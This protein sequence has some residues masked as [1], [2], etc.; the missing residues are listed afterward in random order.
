M[1][2]VAAGSSRT[3]RLGLLS[4][5]VFLSAPFA[6]AV[7]IALDAWRVIFVMVV[8][9]VVAHY[10]D[11]AWRDSRGVKDDEDVEFTAREEADL[12]DTSESWADS[13]LYLLEHPELVARVRFRYRFALRAHT[14]ARPLHWAGF[15]VTLVML[16]QPLW[17]AI[18][19]FVALV[20][21]NSGASKLST[22]LLSRLSERTDAAERE[23]WLRWYAWA[24]NAGVAAMVAAVGFKYLMG[25]Y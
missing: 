11:K 8:L 13:L 18:G 3:R 25:G 2:R 5:A 6:L 19:A 21:D 20:A 7:G 10:V 14:L 15:T 4:F 16:P 17:A 9:L 12:R 22:L 23:R 1:P 24:D